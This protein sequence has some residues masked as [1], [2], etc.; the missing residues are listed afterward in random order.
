MRAL[1]ASCVG[2]MCLLVATPAR[3]QGR[4]HAWLEGRYFQDRDQTR[5]HIVRTGPGGGVAAGVD[6]SRRFAIQVAVDW[7]KAHVERSERVFQVLR[8]GMRHVETIGN[9][10]P[11]VSVL[12]GIHVVTTSRVRV[13]L[14]AGLGRLEAL[15]RGHIVVE[16]LAPDG[17]ALSRV[18]HETTTAGTDSYVRPSAY[19]GRSRD[20]PPSSPPIP[21]TPASARASCATCRGQTVQG[22]A[23]LRGPTSPAA[24]RHR[25]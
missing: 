9:S 2:A 15:T 13:T 3:G 1:V 6:L 14:L 24:S 25:A 18:E 21:P 11:A 23:T 10:A 19:A 20:A 5:D 22:S 12:A 7:P 17:N 16:D 4:F 8:K